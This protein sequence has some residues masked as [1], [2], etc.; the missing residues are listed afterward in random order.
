MRNC[1]STAGPTRQ[2]RSDCEVIPLGELGGMLERLEV[3][4]EAVAFVRDRMGPAP[5]DFDLEM[6]DAVYRTHIRPTLDGFGIH[7]Q[8]IGKPVVPRRDPVVHTD[9]GTSRRLQHG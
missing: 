2:S 1:S 9:S 8:A 3:S 5:G 4:Q 6:L 7:L